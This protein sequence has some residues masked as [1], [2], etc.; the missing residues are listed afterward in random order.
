M[1][2][3]PVV[4]RFG[5]FELDEEAGELRRGGAV[6]AVQPK[7]FALLALLLR[8]RARVVTTD[9]LF[10]ALWPGV[11][12]TPGSLNRAVSHA[13]RAID[14]ANQGE[15]IK[16]FPRRGYRFC[17]DAVELDRAARAD[18]A[19]GAAGA[20]RGGLP[21]VG[22]EDALAILR[23]ALEQAL[24]GRES[25]A[26]VSG[27]AG[28]GKSRLVEVF[29]RE[30]ARRGPLV[31]VGRCR[32]GEG[33]PALWPWVQVVR[34]LLAEPAVAADLRER[35]IATGELAALVPELDGSA[36]ERKTAGLSPEQRRFQF[37]EAI[38]H[39]LQRASRRRPLVVVLEDLHWAG[40]P[41]LRVLEH[42]AFETEPD[43]ILIVATVREESRERGDP[44][45][46]TLSILRRQDRTAQVVLRGLTRGQVAG[47]L[48]Q[49]LGRAAPPDLTSELFAR[50][51]GVPLYLREAIRLLEERGDLEH[52]ERLARTGITL[53]V[54]SF[55]L[56][57]RALD[58][59]S[60]PCHELVAAAAVIG[61]EFGLPFVSAV[62]EIPRDEALDLLDEAARAGVVE[63]VPEAPATWRFSHALYR[64]AAYEA[65]PPGLRV[66]LHYRTAE[67]LERQHA[68]HPD[69]VVAELAFHR[70]QSLALGE[71]ESAYA[72]A[73]RAAEKASS[74]CAYEEAAGHWEQAR[75]ALEHCE[76][77]D[78]ERHLRTLLALGDA[79]RLAGDTRRQ[80]EVFGEAV[81]AARAQDRPTDFARAALGLCDMS[82]WAT[83]DEAARAALAE[84]LSRLDEESR[85]ERARLLT[86]LAYFDVR[87]SRARSEPTARDAV[88]L[89]RRLGEPEALQEALYTLH[90]A[91][92]GPDDLE[93]RQA[94][95]RELVEASGDAPGRDLAVIALL[96][97]ASDRVA[98][99]EAGPARDYR[100]RAAAWAGDDPHPGLLWHLGAYDAGLALLEGR[101]AEAER[102]VEESVLLGLRAGH[103]Y[104][105]GVR[106][107]QRALLHRERG[108]H[109]AAIGMLAPMAKT[110]DGAVH[111]VRAVLARAQ[112]AAEDEAA[113]RSAFEALAEDDF[114][115][116]PR[117]IRWT[118]TLVEASHLCVELGDR[119]RAEALYR[120][121]EPTWHHHGVLPVPICYGGPVARCLAR[122]CE[123]LGQSD[124]ADELYGEAGDACAGLGARPDLARVTLERGLLAAR[125][126][127]A[128][129]A[130]ELLRESARLA[131][132]LGM[133]EVEARARAGLD[134]PS[135][136][137]RA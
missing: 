72:C 44:L 14:D 92:A 35:M 78:P 36:P 4:F 136:A 3:R 121:L 19:Q 127:P 16:S 33:V 93:E 70:H 77:V 123:L 47:I 17:G 41:S 128:R 38:E 53:P 2:D 120:M 45:N 22:R 104:A 106:A 112:L 125:R 110:R 130:R 1:G 50:T 69:R 85:G 57:R 62:A 63:S 88:E 21:F 100:D 89:A 32:E 99:G 5:D 137:P 102:L 117:N 108:E 103:P 129:R 9:E 39:A 87:V 76:S 118:A 29:T 66:R 82:S 116:V 79:W 24:A 12:V 7:P 83:P 94:L 134:G 11:A 52:P 81:E 58:G 60:E 75:A 40:A 119:A 109:E 115:A 61:R 43:P 59:L 132:E 111:W 113:A 31:L 105:R 73:A 122:L 30:V 51:E 26:L 107:A 114:A 25:L 42:L 131:A 8:E 48:E 13:R 101:F 133:A 71:P 126:G 37:F 10:E 135:P 46:R 54:R 65:L 97:V 98:L 20:V 95:T 86:R 56:I 64:E 55:D 15:L 91:I 28:V 124:E 49:K 84:A 90:F 67:R 74:L 27:I 96:D 34:G 6:V 23:G 18:T 80:R 68:D